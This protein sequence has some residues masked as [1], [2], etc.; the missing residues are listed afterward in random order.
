MHSAWQ[1]ELDECCLGAWA[2]NES[3]KGDGCGQD[4]SNNRETN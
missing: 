2:G 1:R 4:L 3:H